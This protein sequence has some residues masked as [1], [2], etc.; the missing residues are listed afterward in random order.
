MLIHSASQL[1]TLS[2]G[3]RRGTSGENLAIIENGAV[4]VQDE[5][6][7]EVGETRALLEKYPHEENWTHREAW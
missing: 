3:T 2:G 6:I 4:L 7:I 5:R 1:L